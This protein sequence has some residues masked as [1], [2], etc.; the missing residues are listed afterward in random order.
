MMPMCGKHPRHFSLE[1]PSKLQIYRQIAA[2]RKYVAKM[3][4]VFRSQNRQDSQELL[5]RHQT[6]SI[7]NTTSLEPSSTFIA[8]FPKIEPE[9]GAEYSQIWIPFATIISFKT[10]GI[11]F[12]LS[13][14][15]KLQEFH[16]T[17][18]VHKGSRHE[19]F[20]FWLESRHQIILNNSKLPPQQ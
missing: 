16:C 19:V 5:A 3:R 8:G 12:S 6:D 14:R 1:Q 11:L 10:G 15:T 13:N 7:K 4:H 17:R 2:F 9:H 20:I 18:V